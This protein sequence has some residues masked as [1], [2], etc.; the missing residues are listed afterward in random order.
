M[1][2]GN[3][4]TLNRCVKCVLSLMVLLGDLFRKS[5][6]RVFGKTPPGTCVVVCYHSVPPGQQQQFA[7]QLES[8][9]KRATIVSL[10]DAVD[11]RKGT[12]SVGITFDDAFE[13]FATCALPELEK[14]RIH[15]TLFVITEALDKAFGP[16]DSFERVMSTEQL[17]SL[18]VHLI[19]IG[20]H[21]ETHPMLPEVSEQDGRRQIVNSKR[22]LEALLGRR[23]ELFCFPF[24]GFNRRLVQMCREAGYQHV[25]STLPYLAFRDQE[26]F[27]IGRVRVDPTDWALEF[28]LKSVGSYR[29][30]PF[31]FQLKRN[32]LSRLKILRRIRGGEL[33][34]RRESSRS[35]I[36]ELS[37]RPFPE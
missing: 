1:R 13:N 36:R 11:L 21:T 8:L 29:W 37:M 9:Q 7:A 23:V 5:L 6:T 32:M 17:K 14:R 33:T 24:G 2:L 30:L 10:G 20:S 28:Y 3:F 22:K 25:F 16:P 31:A 18:P 27:V 35:A 15:A 12:H 4:K 34:R 19:S 26:E